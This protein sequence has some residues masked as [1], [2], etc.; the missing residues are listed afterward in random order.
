MSHTGRP[1]IPHDNQYRG[2]RGS[3]GKVGSSLMLPGGAAWDGVGRGQEQ[4]DILCG[5]REDR[6]KVPHLV[7]RRPDVISID[8]PKD[9]TGDKPGED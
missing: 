7:T 6:W 5:R 2:R 9:D 1:P 8:V 4:P 3:E